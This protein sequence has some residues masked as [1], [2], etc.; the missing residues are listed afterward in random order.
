MGG[1]VKPSEVYEILA[2]YFELSKKE[3]EEVLPSG[4][5]KK[6]DN[7]VAWARSSLC[8]YGFLDRSVRGIWKITEK[9]RRELSRLGLIDRPFP[10]VK[11][12]QGQITKNS[13]RGAKERESEDE[14]ILQ[15]VLGEVAPNGPKRFPE[16][17][18][19]S[20]CSDFYEVELPGTQLHLAPLS[21]TIIT[22]PKGFFRYQAK[23]PSEAKYIL[24]CHKVGL[25]KVNIPS[26]NLT[27]FKAVKAYEKYCDGVMKKSFELFL[28]F[29][30]DEEKSESLSNE[31][32]N[33]LALRAKRN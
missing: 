25:K 28:E 29:F 12:S 20:N 32:A 13:T 23:N 5:S 10:G 33:R 4:I 24:Y 30:N 2:N 27:L 7:R 6:F 26:D 9:G 21:Q 19:D 1:E 3:R 31:V 22:S 15:L 14:E 16:D 17:F 8:A 18:L 11:P